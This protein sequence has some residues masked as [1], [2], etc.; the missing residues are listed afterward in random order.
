MSADTPVVTN[1]SYVPVVTV[2]GPAGVGKTTVSAGVACKLGYHLLISG[3]LYRA[4]A[5]RTGRMEHPG[6]TI[7]KHTLNDAINSLDMS[8]DATTDPPKV[9]LNG[10]DMT[11]ALSGEDCAQC[12][13]QLAVRPDVRNGLS[14]KMKQFRCAPGL[15]A[16]GRDMGTVVFSDAFVKIYLDAPHS[17]RLARRQT[18]LKQNNIG[19]KLH[20]TDKGLNDRD[21][22]DSSR[23]VS[24]LQ[25]AEGAHVIDTSGR[26][27]ASIVNEVADLVK[28]A[29]GQSFR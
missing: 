5:Y 16:E 25:V 27:I 11:L 23:A 7:E 24:P 20:R 15:V 4:L 1:T 8:F 26:T 6:A 21:H 2:D 28:Q 9:M 18:Q 10:E 29:C 17:V 22:R 13:S 3:M 19:G 14:Q 12:A